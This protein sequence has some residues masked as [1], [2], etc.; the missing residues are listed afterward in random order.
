[1]FKL[2]GKCEEKILLA[3][4][5]LANLFL[6]QLNISNF[7]CRK[8]SWPEKWCFKISRDIDRSLEIEYRLRLIKNIRPIDILPWINLYYHELE[9][10]LLV[11]C[12]EHYLTSSIISFIATIDKTDK[13]K[14][15]TQVYYSLWNI[16]CQMDECNFLIHWIRSFI[17]QHWIID[18]P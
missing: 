5:A 17:G 13:F 8:E 6:Q 15:R 11:F 7:V 10:T 1:M 18:S 12:D 9:I 3:L 16:L 2:Y 4:W 14:A